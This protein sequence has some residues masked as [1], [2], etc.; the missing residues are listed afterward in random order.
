M[1]YEMLI[2]GSVE[3]NILHEYFTHTKVLGSALKNQRETN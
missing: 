1:A 2:V 3:D